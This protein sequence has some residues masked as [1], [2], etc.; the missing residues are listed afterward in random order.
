MLARYLA[1]VL[2]EAVNR[3]KKEVSKHKRPRAQELKQ[4]TYVLIV[5]LT[6]QPAQYPC[7][8]LESSSVARSHLLCFQCPDPRVAHVVLVKVSIY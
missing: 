1:E 2:E 7:A 5:I 8:K 6:Q 3:S 4:L